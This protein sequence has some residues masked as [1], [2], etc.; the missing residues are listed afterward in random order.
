[1]NHMQK[2]KMGPVD[3]KMKV[4]DIFFP[5]KTPIWPKSWSILLVGSWTQRLQLRKT[6]W[7][8]F[9]QIWQALMYRLQCFFL[10]QIKAKERICRREKKRWA[11][12][13]MF[14]WVIKIYLVWYK[15]HK[16]FSNVSIYTLS[17]SVF[18]YIGHS[19]K[20]YHVNISVK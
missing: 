10:N 2:G 20:Y 11:K 19:F 9:Y 8:I 14:S 4:S 15:I 18:H 17:W 7:Y 6:T 1:M 12:M 3:C 16:H 13:K 5:E